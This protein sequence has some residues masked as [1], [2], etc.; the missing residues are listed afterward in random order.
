MWRNFSLSHLELYL[1]LLEF[2]DLWVPN[3]SKSFVKSSNI[4]IVKNDD[5]LCLTTFSLKKIQLFQRPTKKKHNNN[6]K[7]QSMGGAI[8][9]NKIKISFFSVS[10]SIKNETLKKFKTAETTSAYLFSIWV[11]WL[12]C[13]NQLHAQKD[14]ANVASMIFTSGRNVRPLENLF[15]LSRSKNYFKW[16]TVKRH[17]EWC[18]EIKAIGLLNN[19]KRLKRNCSW[20]V[21]TEKSKP[22]AE[23]IRD[24][25]ISM[26]FDMKIN[27]LPNVLCVN[28]IYRNMSYSIIIKRNGWNVPNERV[29][30]R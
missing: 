29:M 13:Q 24:N 1:K 17:R 7:A 22:C 28:Y 2:M 30:W 19:W 14:A 25:A 11:Q 26:L 10:F 5:D 3:S 18:I 8:N 27:W 9:Q 23:I 21:K 12:N 20:I 15:P 4:S 6:K 16:K